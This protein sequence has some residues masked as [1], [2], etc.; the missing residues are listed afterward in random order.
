MTLCRMTLKI[1]TVECSLFFGSP[2][3]GFTRNYMLVKE[4]EL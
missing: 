1:V 3:E 2:L 4:S